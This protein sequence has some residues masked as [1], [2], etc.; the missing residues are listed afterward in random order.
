MDL[1]TLNKVIVRFYSFLYNTTKF[2][3]LA[4][5]HGYSFQLLGVSF[6]LKLLGG[7]RVE[8]VSDR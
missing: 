5:S 3:D 7:F 4:N 6:L 2:L 1:D 8:A